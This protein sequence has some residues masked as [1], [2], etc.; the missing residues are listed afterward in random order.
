[1]AVRT[2]DSGGVRGSTG[3]WSALEEEAQELA[4]RES[5]SD[6]PGQKRQRATAA[7]VS[8][9]QLQPYGGELRTIIVFNT[10]ACIDVLCI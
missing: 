8:L 3:P 5:D 1:M 2:S 10:C 9:T 7:A 6:H 4:A